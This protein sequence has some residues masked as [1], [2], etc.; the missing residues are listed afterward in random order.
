MEAQGAQKSQKNVKKW[1]LETG[2]GKDTEKVPK[3]GAWDPQKQWF[4]I[5][6]VA[7]ITK[8]KGLRKAT[9]MSPKRLPKWNQN[10]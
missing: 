9:K 5:V 2:S 10:R 3:R 6:G 1:A 8:S 4:G 7:Q